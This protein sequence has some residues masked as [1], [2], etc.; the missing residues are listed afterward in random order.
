[1]RRSGTPSRL[2]PLLGAAALLPLATRAQGPGDH[3]VLTPICVGDCP[4]VVGLRLNFR[5][6][7]LERVDGVNVTVWSPYEPPKA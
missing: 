4:R 5:D 3:R 2:L 6:R 1:M 7:N